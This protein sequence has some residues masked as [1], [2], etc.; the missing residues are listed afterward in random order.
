MFVPN[1]ERERGRTLPPAALAPAEEEVF[2]LDLLRLRDLAP[3]DP[4]I[5]VW[6][7]RSVIPALDDALFGPAPDGSKPASFAI[8]DAAKLANL[9]ETLDGSGLRH[10]CLFKGDALRDWGHVAPWLVAL[11]PGHRLTRRLFTAADNGLGLWDKA[12]AMYLRSSARLDDLWRHFRKF[13][14]IEDGAG[15]WIYFRFWEP[16][17][18]MMLYRSQSL[19]G[20]VSFFR[21]CPVVIAPEPA[22]RACM[23]LTSRYMAA[24]VKDATLPPGVFPARDIDLMTMPPAPMPSSGGRSSGEMS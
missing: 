15:R 1:V 7:K 4:Q 17:A 22:D 16:V 21:P 13:T 11:E 20:A 3:L 6:P 8:L 2:S 9:P 23:V 5:G 24:P 14:R 12:A 18:L 19:P 10:R